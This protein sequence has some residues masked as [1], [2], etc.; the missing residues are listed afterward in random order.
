MFRKLLS[1]KTVSIAVAALPLLNANV[2]S[3]VRSGKVLFAGPVG[4]GVAGGRPIRKAVIGTSHW[5]GREDLVGWVAKD[6]RR[7]VF[8]RRPRSTLAQSQWIN[9]K[10]STSLSRNILY[11]YMFYTRCNFLRIK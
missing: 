11:R 3:D 1:R 6:I 8:P 5:Q 4:G 7:C 9:L 10:F 2:G